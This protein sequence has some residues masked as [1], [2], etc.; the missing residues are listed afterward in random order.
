MVFHERRNGVLKGCKFTGKT[1]RLPEERAIELLRALRFREGLHN[2]VDLTQEDT[3]LVTTNK[4]DTLK[5][6][7]FLKFDE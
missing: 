2:F 4:E 5:R 1:V 6:K 3:C 7:R